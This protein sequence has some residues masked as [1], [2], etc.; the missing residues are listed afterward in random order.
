M[1][2]LNA[3]NDMDTK[4]RSTIRLWLDLYQEAKRRDNLI[5]KIDAIP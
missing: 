3:I 1:T 2:K 4:Y 5:I